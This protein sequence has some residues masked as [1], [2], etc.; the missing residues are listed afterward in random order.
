MSVFRDEHQRTIDSI[1]DDG[2]RYLAGR[3][4]K[5][6]EDFGARTG[7]VG[8]SLSFKVDGVEVTIRQGDPNLE[9]SLPG[10]W[11]LPPQ[12]RRSFTQGF[13]L[14]VQGDSE[15]TSNRVIC[16][17]LDWYMLCI[18]VQIG[19]NMASMNLAA[20]KSSY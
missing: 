2:W 3:A 10:E 11:N 7:C 9:W 4:E 16:R 1:N 17:P 6:A 20:S 12:D 5:I 14:S 13:R 8:Q 15:S 19:L 18:F